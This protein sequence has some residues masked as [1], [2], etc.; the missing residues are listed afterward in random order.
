MI[1]KEL[2]N[3]LKNK[4]WRLSHLYFIVNKEKKLVVFKR[5]NAQQKF[6]KEKHIRNIILKI[7]Q[8]GFTT[9]ACIDGLDDTLFNEYFNMVIIVHDKESQ[10]KVF[11]KVRLAW[12][13]I[14]KEIKDYMGWKV[15]TDKT[16]E[17]SFDHG[18]TIC[19]SLSSRSGTVN[20]LHISEFG[21]MCA[22]Y[23]Q[24][25][26]EVISG[27]I[28]SV[29][30]GGRIDIESTAEGEV[31]SFYDMFWE[32]WEK[33][34]QNE[35]DYKAHFFSFI[36]DE[37][38]AI[39]GDFELPFDVL[40]MGRKYN[41]SKEKLNWYYFQK[42]SLKDKIKQEYPCTPEE[43]FLSSG[44]KYFDMECLPYQKDLLREC[45]IVGDW[46]YYYSYN[47]SHLYALG[48][49]VAEGVGQDSS[50]CVIFDFTMNRVVATYKSNAIGP[51]I[52]A[53]EIKRGGEKYGECLVAPERNNHGHATL[54]ILKGIY[55][56]I[57][58]E[59]K[60][61]KKTDVKTERLGWQTNLATKPK[62]L[63]E[64]KSVLDDEA[65]AL[66]SK[67]IFDEVRTYDA[68]DINR[69]SFDSE[70]TRHWD[71]LIALSIA[72]QMKRR[73]YNVKDNN[74][75]QNRQD[76]IESSLEFSN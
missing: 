7:R 17:L 58:A 11:K 20:R 16:N 72:F 4:E 40:E 31:G 24:K 54:A 25:A 13:K 14:D 38:Y 50:T 36:D 49:D 71:L 42:K 63:S 21:K 60:Q 32:Y 61:D 18:S 75:Q 68:E 69:G 3:Y 10:E 48:A 59:I 43:A 76:N 30:P 33:E 45:D 56:N 73:V 23:P 41:V 67:E 37:E 51:D 6:N 46:K 57:Y 44:N 12:E 47:P 34:P 27:A 39:D 8:K 65:I 28:P 74:I 26:E 64:L 15:N 2:D 53:Y 35:L 70:Q 1:D 52:F 19:V 66:V 55:D 5:N 9:D 62:M 29:V 22:K